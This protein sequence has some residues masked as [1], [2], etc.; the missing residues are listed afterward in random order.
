[1]SSVN[2]LPT[3]VPEK[4]FETEHNILFDPSKV[5]IY[6]PEKKIMIEAVVK[7]LKKI[8]DLSNSNL[9]KNADGIL[10]GLAVSFSL[11][12]SK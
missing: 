3:D 11:E 10:W 7:M 2:L 1:M 6:Y 8:A 5:D 12:S 4:T 9:I